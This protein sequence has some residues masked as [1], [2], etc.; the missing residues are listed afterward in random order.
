MT[1]ILGYDQEHFHFQA[2]DNNNLLE[3][4]A[5]LIDIA[6]FN[7]VNTELVRSFIKNRKED[8]ICLS[9][10]MRV[11]F[12]DFN[13]ETIDEGFDRVKILQMHF[14]VRTWIRR[15]KKIMSEYGICV[16]FVTVV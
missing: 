14:I 11:T 6:R 10:P 8:V 7:S 2:N 9:N 16:L 13:K 1:V 12:V 4:L 15:L 5:N 3:Y